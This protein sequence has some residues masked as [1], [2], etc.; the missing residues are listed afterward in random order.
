MI[1]SY[2]RMAS[3]RTDVCAIDTYTNSKLH[4]NPIRPGGGV[5]SAT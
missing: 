5:D 3:Q 4:F 1:T 2:I